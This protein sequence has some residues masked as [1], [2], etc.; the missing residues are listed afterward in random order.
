MFLSLKIKY[1]AFKLQIIVFLSAKMKAQTRSKQFMIFHCCRDIVAGSRLSTQNSLHVAL[2]P[3]AVRF[4]YRN[5]RLIGYPQL[6]QQ[7]QQQQ[8]PLSSVT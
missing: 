1:Y 7:Q 2:S 3:P 4:A 5:V 8:H 6:Q